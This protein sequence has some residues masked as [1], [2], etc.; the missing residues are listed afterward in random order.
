MLSD[1]A[2]RGKE[3]ERECVCVCVYVRVGVRVVRLGKQGSWASEDIIGRCGVR[4]RK[5]VERESVCVYVRVRAVQIG[6]AHV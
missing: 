4:A 1:V 3:R 5:A 2:A 6:R